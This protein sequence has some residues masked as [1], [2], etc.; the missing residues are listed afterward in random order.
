MAHVG[1]GLGLG[2]HEYPMLNPTVDQELLP[3]MVLCIEPAHREP[4]V[5]GYHL[6]DLVLV[7]EDGVKPL[8]DMHR[9]PELF[10]IG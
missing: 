6:E 1:H 4:G 3:G 9:W 10:A 5:A 7:T 8:T 2:L